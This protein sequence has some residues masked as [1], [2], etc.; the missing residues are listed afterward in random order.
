[1]CS[2]RIKSIVFISCC[3]LTV[4]TA[5][6]TPLIASDFVLVSPDFQNG[7][8]LP[9]WSV[10]KA[11]GGENLSPALEWSNPPEGT[12]S[13]ALAVIDE[14][15][16]ARRWVHWLVVNIPADV[17]SLKRGASLKAMPDGATELRNSYGFIGY[18]GPQPPPGTGPH[19]YV[20]TVYALDVETVTVPESPDADEF[21]KAVK[22][23]VLGTAKL[24]GIYER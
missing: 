17:R 23:H 22:P 10:M 3:L 16:V 11:A 13:F 15:P 20:F 9:V 6:S 4:L 12:R 7:K 1:M 14:H 24:I 8:S 19:R 21:E 2:C 18:G 5:W